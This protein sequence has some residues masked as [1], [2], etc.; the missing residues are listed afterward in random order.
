MT[1]PT[2]DNSGPGPI[3]VTP[4]IDSR[5][6]AYCKLPYPGH[7][8]GCPNFGRR[9]ICPPQAPRFEKLIDLSLP[10]YCIYHRFDL[11]GHVLKLRTN[12]PDWSERK[13]HCCLYWQGTARKQ[14]KSKCDLFL[15]DH[16]EYIIFTCPEGNGVDID[17]TVRQISIELQWPAR[18][19]AYKI[20]LAAVSRNGAKAMP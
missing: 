10:I 2:I 18:D 14:L 16:P 1:K 9:A 8:R 15:Q 3:I 6:R 17:A 11:G 4:V 20:A 12:H 13:L 7:P 19:Y 5:V